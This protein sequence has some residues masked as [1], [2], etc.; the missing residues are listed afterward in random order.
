MKFNQRIIFLDLDGVLVTKSPGVFEGDLVM[1]LK[2]VVEATG[3]RIV[4]SS[5]WRR[6]RNGEDHARRSLQAYGLEFISCTPCFSPYVHQRPTEILQWKKEYC[7]TN[8][9][10]LG[11]WIAIDD[12][13]LLEEQH[14]SEMQGHFVHTDMN[15]GLDRAA[16]LQCI[17]LLLEQVHSRDT[18]DGSVS[19][20]SCTSTVSN[21]STRT[22]T[23]I[24]STASTLT[25]TPKFRTNETTTSV[26]G[27]HAFGQERVILVD[28][29]DSRIYGQWTNDLFALKVNAARLDNHAPKAYNTYALDKAAWRV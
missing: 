9:L 6:D 17:Q 1:N 24:G 5:D 13:N 8:R 3:A 7:R 29:Y 28:N 15:V 2:S 25:S 22:S 4:L 27:F 14:G 11:A 18:A 26:R 19:P 20:T 12:R 16:A 23:S 21:A 10:E